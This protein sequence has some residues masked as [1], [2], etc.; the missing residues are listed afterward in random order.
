[1]TSTVKTARPGEV[2]RELLGRP[3]I[4]DQPAVCDPLGA[5]LA[6]EA[7]YEAVTLGGY[8]I[9]AHL[10]LTSGLSLE[11]IE[12]TARAVIRACGLPLLVDADIG[13]GGTEDIPGA[14]ARLEP[15][16]VAAI[17]VSGQH[18][19]AELPYSAA[20]ERDRAHRGLL[21]RVRAARAAR[22][23]MLIMARCTVPPGGGYDGALGQAAGLLE[24][25]ADAVVLHAPASQLPRFPRDLPGA[26]LIYAGSL[27]PGP[28]VTASQLQRWG[29][30][31][32]SVQY[33]RCYCTRMVAAGQCAITWMPGA[34][35]RDDL[36]RKQ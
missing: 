19:P 33:H 34:E 4:L 6:R 14:V 10:P 25:G 11:D 20:R 13:W 22:E 28:P 35:H 31:G 32:L 36:E 17:E 7:G 9:G 24:A 29:Y 21:A 3:A 26:T 12:R 18:L 2:L 1:V 8:A 27:V 5:R 16:G 30:R 15:A 23:H